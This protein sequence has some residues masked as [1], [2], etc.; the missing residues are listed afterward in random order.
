MTSEEKLKAIKEI[1]KFNMKVACG[2]DC[3]KKP[4]CLCQ[5]KRILDIIEKK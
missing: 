1:V 2:N 3:S 5:N 4:D